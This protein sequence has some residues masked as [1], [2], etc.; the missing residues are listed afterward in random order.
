MFG[1][2]L[3]NYS[4]SGA[5]GSMTIGIISSLCWSNNYPSI[6]AGSTNENTV[7]EVQ[8]QVSLLWDIIV[9]PLLFG[10]I[11]CALDF[12]LISS[13]SLTKG[14]FIVCIG[15]VFRLASAYLATWNGQLTPKERLFIALAW[16]PKATVQAALCTF[17]LLRVKQTLSPD[18]VHYNNYIKWTE[19]ILSTAILSICITAPIG[20]ISIKFLGKLLLR[21]DKQEVLVAVDHHHKTLDLDHD[22]DDD[23][24]SNSNQNV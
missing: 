15:S 4:G 23:S 13:A 21:H 5:M 2:K 12:D 1:M 14:V 18:D 3:L 24:S 17:P 7:K 11:G 19:Q 22:N 10:S 6:F 8:N 20:V 16:L 9:E